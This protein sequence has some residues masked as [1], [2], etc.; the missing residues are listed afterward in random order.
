MRARVLPLS[1]LALAVGCADTTAIVVDVSGPGIQVPAQV[2]GLRFIALSDRGTRVD[3]AFP[4]DSLPQ[5]LSILPSSSDDLGVT[6]TVQ[7]TQGGGF[8]AQRVVRSAFTRGTAVHVPVVIEAACLGVDCGMGVDCVAGVCAQV[9]TDGGVDAGG[10]DAG[11]FD[12]GRDAGGTDAGGRDGGGGGDGGMD[13]GRR[14]AGLDAGRPDGGFDGGPP[15]VVRLIISEYV[16]GTSFNKAVELTNLGTA[17]L[18]LSRCIL[19]RYSNGASTSTNIALSG[20]LAVRAQHVVCHPSIV[21]GTGRCDA[22]TATIDHNG[23][24]AYALE[25]D[26]AVV[27]TFGQIGFNPGTAWTGGGL[28]TADYVLRRACAIT[29]GDTVGSDAFDPSAQFSGTVYTDPTASHSGLGTR[30]ECP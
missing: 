29:M 22:M 9:E 23:N 11:A 21:V 7:A 3:R 27:D 26:G 4:I 1:F 25:C 19:R 2:D 17:P 24:D 8:V 18:D 5:S 13:A 14:D 6:I 16:E 30:A 15:G 10:R 20:T 12:A 28:S